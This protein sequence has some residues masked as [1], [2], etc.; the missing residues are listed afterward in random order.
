MN[1]GAFVKGFFVV[2]GIALLLISLIG[3]ASGLVASTIGGTAGCII[4]AAIT[5][6]I[7]FFIATGWTGKKSE[8]GGRYWMA[9]I[10]AAGTIIGV[11]VSQQIGGFS[12]ILVGGVTA[13]C[14]DAVLFVCWCF[15]PKKK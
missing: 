15:A 2:F 11:Y 7:V 8:G 9:T 3:F 10:F 1:T 5:A 12:G 14:A 4:A 13:G 6:A